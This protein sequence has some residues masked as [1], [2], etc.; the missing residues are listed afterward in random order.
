M[1]KVHVSPGASDRLCATEM[2]IENAIADAAR[3]LPGM[4]QARL[5][6]RISV[7]VGDDATGKAAQEALSET[8][9]R[10]VEAR[11]RGEA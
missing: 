3:L 5:D 11:W 2:A 6:L 1:D 4:A 10:L 9:R 7:V 8:R